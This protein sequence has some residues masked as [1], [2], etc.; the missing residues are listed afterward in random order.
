F[1]EARDFIEMYDEEANESYYSLEFDRLHNKRL[2]DYYRL[3]WSLAYRHAFAAPKFTFEA[4]FSIQNLLNHENIFSR[5]FFLDLNEDVMI[6]PE[7]FSVDRLLLRRTPQVLVR[8]W[9]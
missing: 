9:W 2:P 6:E 8:V 3:D 4:A 1:S 7:I 5:N